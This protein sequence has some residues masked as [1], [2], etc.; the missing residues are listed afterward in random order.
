MWNETD[1]GTCTVHRLF[2]TCL[3]PKYI[4][5]NET[6]NVQNRQIKINRSFFS[7]SIEIYWNTYNT[8]KRCVRNINSMNIQYL[9]IFDWV[10]ITRWNPIL[11]VETLLRS[12]NRLIIKCFNQIPYSGSQK[13]ALIKPIKRFHC[14]VKSNN[15][16]VNW[17]YL[18]S[19]WIA[20]IE[21]HGLFYLLFLMWCFQLNDG[22]KIKVILIKNRNILT[23]H[24]EPRTKRKTK[25]WWAQNA[26]PTNKILNTY[27]YHKPKAC[28]LFAYLMFCFVT[29][30]VAYA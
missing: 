25:C 30:F 19:D 12:Q 22:K 13:I 18:L 29:Q 2:Y 7:F 27:L 15:I 14:K 9:Q 24:T 11:L 6:F 1:N 4:R 3:I 10:W 20:K 17:F 23:P 8:T 26:R 28:L 21:H 16:C 5:W